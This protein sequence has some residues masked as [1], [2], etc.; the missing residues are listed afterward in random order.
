[1]ACG[2]L[3]SVMAGI[4]ILGCTAMY[5]TSA[6]LPL[7][8]VKTDKSYSY[9]LWKSCARNGTC[10]KE[11]LSCSR[12]SD[13]ELQKCMNL[14]IIRMFLLLACIFSGFTSIA[15]VKLV[16][17]GGSTKTFERV[18]ILAIASFIFGMIAFP[19]GIKWS[20]DHSSTILSTAAILATTGNGVNLLAVIT[21]FMTPKN[22]ITPFDANT[23]VREK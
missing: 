3:W 20:L 6:I 15:V 14:I 16:F 4:L 11:S 17:T 7:W 2:R 22:E 18:R 19:V 8:S 10:T 9:G 23:S 13:N 5:I 21:I 12:F 1:M